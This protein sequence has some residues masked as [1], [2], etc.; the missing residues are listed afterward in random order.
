MSKCSA[1]I[2]IKPFL[3]CMILHAQGNCSS[4]V[5][6][7][8]NRQK[9][10]RH[11]ISASGEFSWAGGIIADK[12]G[13]NCSKLRTQGTSLVQAHSCYLTLRFFS[14]KAI[15]LIQSNNKKRWLF[16]LL[17]L[18]ACR[19]ISRFCAAQGVVSFKTECAC[20]LQTI[21]YTLS[22]FQQRACR[23]RVLPCLN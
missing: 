21:S 1:R 11:H 16:L 13:N 15:Q 23:R 3:P 20:F 9:N 22:L 17:S 7:W 5:G 14:L 12:I 2:R 8:Q 19:N 10:K 4:N 6:T 18:E